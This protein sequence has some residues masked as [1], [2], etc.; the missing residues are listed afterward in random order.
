MISVCL[1]SDGLVNTIPTERYDVPVDRVYASLQ[2]RISPRLLVDKTPTYAAEPR[3]L[4]RA[5][6]HFADA[7]YIHLVRQPKPAVESFCRMRF[8]RFASHRQP[9]WFCTKGRQDEG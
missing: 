5:E 8:H 7:R 9:L 6:R 2:E 1:R 4:E 3:W